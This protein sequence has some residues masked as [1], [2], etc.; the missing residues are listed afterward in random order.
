MALKGTLQAASKLTAVVKSSN[1]VLQAKSISYKPSTKL[2]ELS[3][4][5]VTDR[6]E[7]SIIVWD[8]ATHTFKV[9]SRLENSN[10][11]IV[12]GSF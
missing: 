10:T 9:K 5:D 8:E 12:G 2:A 1:E 4:I 11:L 3:D 6:E 7:G